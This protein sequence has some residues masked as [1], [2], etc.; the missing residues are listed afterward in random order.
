MNHLVCVVLL[1]IVVSVV[2]TL[3]LLL[4]MTARGRR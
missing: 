2:A 1:S 3:T 4:F